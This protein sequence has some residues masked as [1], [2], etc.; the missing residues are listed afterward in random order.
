MEPVIELTGVGF[1][2]STSESPWKQ[3]A[4]SG[5]DLT[6]RPG[7]YLAI[8]GPNGSGKSTLAKMLNGLLVPV[9]GS[10]RVEGLDTRNPDAVS[11]VRR[12]VGM[13][14]QN[15]DNQIVG[16]TVRDD[17]AFGLENLGVPRDEMIRRIEKVL[18][19]VGLA[20]ME[21]RSPHHLSGGQK[22]RLAI[23]GVLAMRPQVIVF[24]ESTSMLDPGG[25]REVLQAI[26]DL[27]RQGTTVIHI[28]HSAAEASRAE[29]IAVMTEGSIRRIGSP[30]EVFRDP[31]Q[32]RNWLLE[33]P[34]SVELLDRLRKRGMPVR[35]GLFNTDELVEEL[36]A[37][38]SRG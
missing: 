29:R 6:V 31:D 9:K 15:P 28:T 17:I 26:G 12:K 3:W 35:S 4:L 38:L 37:L 33:P 20:G 34:P 2:Y 18:Q 7:E 21:E 13:V 32:L 16:T 22:Q 19:R 27:Q 23:A 14:F 5:V 24:D 30:G 1:H 10:V 25:R 11:T 8:M 36:W